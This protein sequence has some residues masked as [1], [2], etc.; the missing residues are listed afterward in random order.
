MSPSPTLPLTSAQIYA[1]GV[2]RQGL[3]TLCLLSS[4]CDV[5]SVR[6]QD[7][8]EQEMGLEDE[9]LRLSEPYGSWH[10]GL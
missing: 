3:H 8:T 7:G 1:V 9:E 2:R 6:S 5:T 4:S 10:E